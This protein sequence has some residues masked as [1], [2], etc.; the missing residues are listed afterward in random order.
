MH[1]YQLDKIVKFAGEKDFTDVIVVNEDQK[2]FS[3]C[4]DHSIRF[5]RPHEFV[6]NWVPAFAPSDGILH[7]HLPYGPTAHYRL[8]SVTCSKDIP[9]CAVIDVVHRSPVTMHVSIEHACAPFV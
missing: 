1:C 7:F 8:S 6:T 2:K 5:M 9:V 4:C 3:T